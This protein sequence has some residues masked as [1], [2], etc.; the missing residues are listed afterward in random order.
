M[1]VSVEKYRQ[2]YEDEKDVVRTLKK[3]HVNNV[4]VSFIPRKKERKRVIVTKFHCL[5][6][7]NIVTSVS[8]VSVIF[9]NE[10]SL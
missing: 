9:C 1:S 4:K 7:N 2:C 5:F 3:K 10:H 6:K 8:G